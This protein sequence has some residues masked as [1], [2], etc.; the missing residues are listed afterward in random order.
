MM[1]YPSIVDLLEK[2]GSKYSL[3]I[4][5]AKRTRELCEQQD[6]EDTVDGA[7]AIT[8]AAEELAEGTVRVINYEGQDGIIEKVLHNNELAQAEQAE[9]EE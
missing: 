5:A 2:C 9:T 6:A 8:K 7:R 4:A 3:V 1:L